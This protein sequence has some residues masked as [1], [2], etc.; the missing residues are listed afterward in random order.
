MRDAAAQAL[1]LQLGWSMTY[2]RKLLS[3]LEA[4]GVHLVY[5]P[6]TT[7]LCS[8]CCAH[9]ATQES[10]FCVRCTTEMELERQ[11]IADF[12][13]E[14]RL[15]EEAERETN[16]VKK[17]RERMRQEFDANPRKKSLTGWVEW[18]LENPHEWEVMLS[19]AREL[20]QSD[21][22]LAEEAARRTAG[23]LR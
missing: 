5:Q 6:I 13:E 11:R 9:Y 10:G 12:E 7:E 16:E 23:R 22:T 4:Q 20:Y 3:E 17:A 1:A 19:R 18:V 14:Q 2:V 8:N 15:R 21:E